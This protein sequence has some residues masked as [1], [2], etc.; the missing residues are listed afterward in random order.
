MLATL[1]PGG[2]YVLNIIDRPPMRFGRAEAATL[3]QVFG[4]AAL[5]APP[6]LVEQRAGGNLVLVA[7]DRELDVD[8]L[9]DR[10]ADRGGEEVVVVD[11]ELA[12]FERGAP[13]LTDDHA[14]VDQWL[15][16]TRRS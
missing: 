7:S 9:R 8:A 12:A 11:G 13:A 2:V 15:A 14:P 1:R 6:A 5:V 10:I 3:R 4:H 16:R